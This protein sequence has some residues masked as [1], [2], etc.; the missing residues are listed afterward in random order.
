MFTNIEVFVCFAAQIMHKLMLFPGIIVYI[1]KL[2]HKTNIYI[3]D[4]Y[5]YIS[6]F[7]VL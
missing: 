5:L 7:N 4:K 1:F 3:A 6:I 2:R